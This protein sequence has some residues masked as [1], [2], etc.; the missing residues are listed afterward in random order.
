MPRPVSANSGSAGDAPAHAEYGGLVRPRLTARLTDPSAFRVGRVVAPAGCGK[1][2]LLAHV[3]LAYPGP[4]AWCGSPDPVPRSEE[5]LAAWL[6]DGLAPALGRGGDPAAGIEGV[7][8]ALAGQGQALLAVLDDVHLLEGSDAEVALAELTRRLPA[9]LRLLLA[10]RVS[11]ALDLTRLRVAGQLTEIGPDELRFRTWEVEELF[12]DVY[13][14]PL[15]PEDAATLARRTAGWAAY[16]QLFHLATVDKTAGERHRLLASLVN[17][18]RLVMEYLTRNVLAELSTDLQEFLLRTCVL[19]R[20]TGELCDE[21]LGWERGSQRLL[22][23]LERRQLFTERLDEAG[24]RYHAVLLSFLEARL[25]E[26]AGAASARRQHRRA[27]LLL[28]RE[29]YTEDA[30]AAFAKAEDWE[31]VA[32]T[33]GHADAAAATF[34]VAWL[35]ALPSAVVESDALLLMAR[36]RRFVACGDLADAVATMRSAELLAASSDIAQRCREERDQVAAWL[37]PVAMTG[38]DW[39][40]VIRAATRCQPGAARRAAESLPGATGRFAL[41]ATAFLAGDLLGASRLLKGVSAHPAA[42]PVLA[43][44]AQ[45]LEALSRW[46]CGN[47]LDEHEREQLRDRVEHIGLPWLDRACRAVLAA[48]GTS[49]RDELDEVGDACEREGDRWGDGLV[50]LLRALQSLHRGAIAGASPAGGGTAVDDC[51]RAATIFAEIGAGVLELHA[52]AYL[53]L[54]ACAQGDRPGAL[55]SARRARSLGSLLAAPELSGLAALAQGAALADEAELDRARELL[56][57]LGTWRWHHNL[58]RSLP[59]AP[60]AG[61]SGEEGWG[62]AQRSSALARRRNGWCRAGGT[63]PDT[64]RGAPPVRLRC[65]GGFSLDIGGRR[66][67]ESPAKPMER[68]LLHLLAMRAGEP[69]HRE[70]LIE[71]LWPASAPDAGRHRLQVAVSSLRRLLAAYEQYGTLLARE[72]EAYRL[73]IGSDASVDVWQFDVHVRVAALAR[74]AGE[75]AGEERDLAAALAAYGGPLLPADGPAEWVVA[76][77]ARLEASA[78]DAAARLARLRLD[79]GTF[80]AAADAA[81]CGLAIDRYRDEL[82]NL[83]IEANQRSGHRAEAGRA[84]RSYAAVLDEL[85]M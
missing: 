82:W 80:A 73:A 75:A 84:R 48:T 18:S 50:A 24:Y 65:L 54:A 25:V 51:R 3:A 45:L 13:H 77:R 69:T 42:S 79:A 52:E 1:S 74:T 35:E 30:V 44:A 60:G 59:G 71:A 37:G 62:E 58:C 2:W 81:R 11:P 17:R 34:G 12:R 78:V 21:L 66:V 8:G 61:P 36:A 5:A 53:A 67:D 49:R 10:C 38:V 32:R 56:E 31:G 76:E 63:A 39:L 46:M 14:D 43:V 85:G 47:G 57:P 83:L 41:G 9:R 29:G 20:P 72:G 4:V 55:A 23:E 70:I 27:A 15:N 64:V 19:R 68:A 26:S 22:A 28:E 7:V 40:A 33:L 16:L 6:W